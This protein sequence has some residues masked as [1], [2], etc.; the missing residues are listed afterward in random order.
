MGT[1]DVAEKATGRTR[2]IARELGSKKL[3]KRAEKLEKELSKTAKRIERELE[4]RAQQLPI[5][6]PFDKRRRHRARRRGMKTGV[7]AAVAGTAAY[8]VKR[9]GGQQ[10]PFQAP[11][12]V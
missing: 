7:L 10:P 5:D 1:S 3:I 11:T 8:L 12:S 6:T 2:D 4:K 9:S